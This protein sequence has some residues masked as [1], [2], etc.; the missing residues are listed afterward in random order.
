VVGG[1]CGVTDDHT[2]DLQVLVLHP[3]RRRHRGQYARQVGDGDDDDEEEEDGEVDEDVDDAAAAADDDGD[4][5][6]DDDDDDDDDGDDDD[7]D[8]DDDGD[9]D[10]DDDDDDDD[11]ADDDDDDDADDE[12]SSPPPR[13]PHRSYYR[14]KKEFRSFRVIL[15]FMPVFAIVMAALFFM[16]FAI[17]GP[18]L[19]TR[20]FLK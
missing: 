4:D 14:G 10:D 20:F 8:D 12:Y 16:L 9:V 1:S 6:G 17:T 3:P 2:G 7:D 19:W 15:R 11:D 18:E 5:D 13:I